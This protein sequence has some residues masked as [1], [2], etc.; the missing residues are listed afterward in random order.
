MKVC[1][2]ISSWQMTLPDHSACN[3]H[4]RHYVKTKKYLNVWDK[5]RKNTCK[6]QR[7]QVQ[8]S[9]FYSCYYSMFFNSES[10][11]KDI[12]KPTGSNSNTSD[13]CSRGVWFEFYDMSYATVVFWGFFSVCSGKCLNWDI[14]ISFHTL[15]NY[16]IIKPFIIWV[17]DSIV[18]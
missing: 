16:L 11:L 14:S 18:I 17:T 15:S 9:E 8:L 6:R 4:I 3:C 1:S 12:T 5:Q 13:F 10:D 2:S 7:G